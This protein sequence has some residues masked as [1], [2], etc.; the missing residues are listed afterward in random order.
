M[1]PNATQSIWIT[2]VFFVPLG[3]VIPSVL[4]EILR[5]IWHR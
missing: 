3:F 1:E 2:A 4:A 5:R